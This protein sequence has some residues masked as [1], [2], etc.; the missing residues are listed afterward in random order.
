MS[1]E[2][3]MSTA[4]GWSPRR[5]ELLRR[6]HALGLS[7]AESAELLGG[8]TRGAVASKRARL[9]LAPHPVR[10]AVFTAAT[11]A[12]RRRSLVEVPEFRV[13]PLP[14]MDLPLP[15]DAK[16]KRLCDQ[17]LRECAWPLGTADAQGDHHT[18]FCCAPVKE[19]GPYCAHHRAIARRE[20]GRAH[21]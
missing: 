4:D 14:D 16:P 12:R 9:G 15:C 19:R 13:E 18:L 11:S 7:S 1:V 5:L 21:V 6:H 2:S 20:I 10:G 3:F 17:E 8:V